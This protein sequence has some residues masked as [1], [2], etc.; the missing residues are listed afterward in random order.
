MKRVY[1]PRNRITG[2]GGLSIWVSRARRRAAQMPNLRSHLAKWLTRLALNLD[3]NTG[4]SP[5]TKGSLV[6]RQAECCPPPPTIAVQLQ[7]TETIEEW[8]ARVAGTPLRPG[9]SGC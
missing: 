2:Q 6:C 8:Q 5:Q 7:S 9:R 1:I 3:P 4:A